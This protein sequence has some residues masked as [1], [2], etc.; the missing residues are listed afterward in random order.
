MAYKM[1]SMLGFMQ[2]EVRVYSEQ[3]I[4]T[5]ER[6]RKFL[7]NESFNI[8][9]GK[10]NA[11]VVLV[12]PAQGQLKVEIITKGKI[13]TACFANGSQAQAENSKQINDRIYNIYEMLYGYKFAE[14]KALFGF[15]KPAANGSASFDD[16]NSKITVEEA[17]Y[18]SK[19]V[20]TKTN[21]LFAV[22]AFVR[23][24]ILLEKYKAVAKFNFEHKAIDKK[25]DQIM[26]QANDEE[27]TNYFK[28]AILSLV[29]V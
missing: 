22:F 19:V 16:H 8:T 20:P 3:D 29:C 11:I 18:F 6:W 13:L 5:D 24:Y 12:N 1:S 23:Y 26:E 28:A 10:F 27:L 2:K 15:S 21:P 14:K 17:E 9:S 25:V 4:S 7:D